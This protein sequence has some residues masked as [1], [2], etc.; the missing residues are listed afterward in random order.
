MRITKL[1]IFLI[2]AGLNSLSLAKSSA[3]TI[4]NSDASQSEA[5]FVAEV[6]DADTGRPIPKFLALAGVNPLEG[7]GWQWQGHTAHEFN[8][9]Q[10]RWPPEGKRGYREQVLRIEAEGYI[11]HQTPI[12]Q[13]DTQGAGPENSSKASGV[14]SE[15]ETQQIRL[16]RDLGIES[17]VHTPAGKPVAGA[18]VAIGMANDEIVALAGTQVSH[19][20]VRG[21]RIWPRQHRKAETDAD[22]RF[23]LPTEIQPA[24]VVV[25]HEVGV[26]VLSYQEFQS[27]PD[28]QLK[29]WGRIE[30]RVLWGD[31]PAS[32]VEV[33]LISHGRKGD[34]ELQPTFSFSA[35]QT[36]ITDEEGRFS[37]EKVPPGPAQISGPS[38]HPIQFVDIL[39]GQPT[40]F[41]LGG[42]G[43]PVVGQLTGRTTWANVKVRIAPTAPSAGDMHIP[44]SPWPSYLQFLRSPAGKLYDQRDIEVGADGQ[45]TIPH[46]PPEC[47]QLFVDERSSDG[48][49][50]FV[51]GTK[52][53]V[54]TVPGG[55]SDIPLDVGA[56]KIRKR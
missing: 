24:V 22:G 53:T 6:V 38:Y 31:Q 13:S 4:E 43:R 7:L 30:G 14:S 41:V 37:F 26:A 56:I 50:Q 55:K 32:V 51:G 27:Q 5:F 17:R 15:S 54:E 36:S 45:F 47:Y 18:T 46:V 28:I 21:G 20:Q 2:C 25:A 52:F 16:R 33:T 8:E 42:L 3:Q 40:G 39:A 34:K 48:R 19:G 23:T 11:P 1:S 35:V 9:G 44:D 12:I 49:L 29:P 10:L